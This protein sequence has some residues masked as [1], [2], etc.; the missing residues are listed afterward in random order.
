MFVAALFFTTRAFADTIQT[1]VVSN[2]QSPYPPPEILPTGTNIST[3]FLISTP[4]PEPVEG[5]VASPV[6]PISS[7]DFTEYDYSIYLPIIFKTYN[8]IGAIDYADNWAH[9]RNSNYPN[10]GT[11]CGC[12]DCTNYVSQ[13]LHNGGLPL[14]TGN[15]D[16]NSV[17]EWW[18]RK[19]LWWYENSITW[20]ATPEFNTYLFQYPNDF[21]FWSWPT[22][23][24]GG[25]FFLMDLHGA[26]LQDPPDGI[27]DHARFV[28][29]Y[30]WTSTNQGDYT[31][32]CGTNLTIPSSTYELLINQHCVD[33]K[34]V[35]WNYGVQGG[36]GFWPFH[37]K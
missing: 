23:L 14:R 31:D 37:V 35:V 7:F 11:G 27:P 15:W 25:D 33:R 16:E 20:S 24:E 21:E 10:Y 5:S 2:I 30:G 1:T 4:Y 3:D 13:A 34:R 19:V 17:F 22:D 28:V 32:G 26:T 6:L 9:D 29:G 12:N 18:Y 8:R 36:V